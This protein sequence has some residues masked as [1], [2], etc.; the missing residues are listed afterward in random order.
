[1]VDLSLS[2]IIPTVSRPTLA[3]TLMSLRGQAW[4]PG[5]EIILVGDGPQPI[6]A[7]LWRQFGLPGRGTVETPARLGHWGHGARNWLLDAR[8]AAGAY[9]MALDDDDEMAP[10]AVAAVRAALT[11]NPGR[12]HI[13]RMTGDPC[14]G[15]AWRA[16]VIE[17]GN[18]GTPCLVAPNDPARLGRY[19]PRHGGDCDFIRE[20]CGQNPAGP[21]WREEV[22]A[23]IRPP[24]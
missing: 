24:T 2:L 3:R 20:T 9:L 22:I 10:G 1:M 4:R 12:P 8:A 13:F 11:D 18:V 19:A 16:K 5:D 15:T 6:A 7:D 17:H 21:V 14:G 23:L